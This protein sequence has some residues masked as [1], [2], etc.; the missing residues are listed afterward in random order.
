MLQ[1]EIR[2]GGGIPSPGQIGTR[3]IRARQIKVRQTGTRP[4][5]KHPIPNPK[6]HVFSKTLNL[7]LSGFRVCGSKGR[8]FR[9]IA[10]EM[11][12]K[13]GPQKIQKTT[14]FMMRR[15]R[16]MTGSPPGV[17]EPSPALLQ[18]LGACVGR[19]C[20]RRTLQAKQTGGLNALP[21]VS[22][23]RR[24]R[25]KFRLKVCCPYPMTEGISIEPAVCHGNPVL[26][27]TRI[28]CINCARCAYW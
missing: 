7:F 8:R 16:S 27:G 3:H 6:N 2:S 13:Q 24:S 5:P 21:R 26:K 19:A 18:D 28:L 15:S 25:L 12:L 10:L 22:H 20:P 4:T 1:R 11:R 17:S 14:H 9:P 23:P